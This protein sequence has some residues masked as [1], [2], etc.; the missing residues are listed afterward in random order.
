MWPTAYEGILSS[1]QRGR[2]GLRSRGNPRDWKRPESAAVVDL[3]AP[4]GSGLCNNYCV[5]LVHAM[6]G[7]TCATQ[8]HTG[9]VKREAL[10]GRRFG[11]LLC[12]RSVASALAARRASAAMAHC[13]RRWNRRVG[14]FLA[15]IST[16]S[17]R[18]A[19]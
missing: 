4:Y 3:L 17:G 19:V 11:V 14:G 7:P 16:A 5:V 10:C 8:G 12:F 2:D 15:R 18:Q 13:A 9:S 6:A 1:W